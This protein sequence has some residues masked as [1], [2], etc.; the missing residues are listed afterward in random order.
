MSQAHDIRALFTQ[1]HEEGKPEA[2]PTKTVRDAW[3]FYKGREDPALT[4]SKQKVQTLAAEVES[5][6][7]EVESLKDDNIHLESTIDKLVENASFKNYIKGFRYITIFFKHLGELDLEGG[8]YDTFL[9]YFGLRRVL[10][11]EGKGGYKIWGFLLQAVQKRE[12]EGSCE[13]FTYVLK[14]KKK[15][16]LHEAMQLNLTNL[17]EPIKSYCE[18]F[19]IS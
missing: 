15:E 9:S 19:N 5:L 10:K 8:I 2:P 3:N 17:F 1:L 6:T 12:Y 7:T 18:L 16:I 11:D 13:Q 4:E 14:W